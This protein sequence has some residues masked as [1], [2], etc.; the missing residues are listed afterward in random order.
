MLATGAA[1][2]ARDPDGCARLGM[3][4]LLKFDQRRASMAGL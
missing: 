2:L 4:R 3:T 1:A